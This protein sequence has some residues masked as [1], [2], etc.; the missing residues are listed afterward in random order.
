[1]VDLS[2]LRI[3]RVGDQVLVW[4]LHDGEAVDEGGVFLS[5]LRE[6]DYAGLADQWGFDD[7]G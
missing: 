1:V 6:T 3:H 7:L 4:Y 5:A 2:G